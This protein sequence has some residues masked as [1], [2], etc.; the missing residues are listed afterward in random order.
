MTLLSWQLLF[1]IIG[2]LVRLLSSCCIHFCASEAAAAGLQV[3]AAL[4]DSLSIQLL[5]LWHCSGAA[6]PLQQPRKEAR[7]QPP[8]LL[9]RRRRRRFLRCRRERGPF[10]PHKDLEAARRGRLKKVIL[11]ALLP[12]LSR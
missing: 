3:E 6:T 5:W 11:E 10:S 7:K 8:D 4:G 1:S 9:R 2:F 12:Y